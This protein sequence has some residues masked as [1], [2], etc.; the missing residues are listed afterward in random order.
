MGHYWD[1]YARETSFCHRWPPL[2]KLF[3]AA[4]VV[5]VSVTVPLRCWPVLVG[6]VL[7]VGVGHGLAKIPWNYSIRRLAVFGGLLSTLALSV[8]GAQAFQ[9]GWD[10]AATILVRGLLAF[11]TALWLVNVMPF[12][13]LLATLKRLNVSAVLV[14]VLSFMYR[15]SFVLWDELDK[16]LTARRA[17]TFRKPSVRQA[18]R[19]SA[20]LIGML[21][22]RAMGR[23]ERVHGAMCARGWN[24][25]VRTLDES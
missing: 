24:G 8:P 19:S 23:A 6:A 2:L 10:I 14:A 17:R 1:H 9:A 12:D 25:R 18:W 3:S 21:V 22:I 5:V 4:V 13:Q 7:L 16:M 20:Y 15:Y 11:Y